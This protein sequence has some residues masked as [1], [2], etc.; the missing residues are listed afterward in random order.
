MQIQE[1][2]EVRDLIQR[3]LAEDVADGDATTLALVPGDARVKAEIVARHDCV[4]AGGPVAA[5]VFRA[6]DEQVVYE[7]GVA[8]GETVAQ[9]ARVATIDGPARGILTAERT[10][11][12]LTA[13]DRDRDPD[14]AVC[15]SRQSLRNHDSGYAQD[16][17][18]VSGIGKVCC[19]LWGWSQPSHGAL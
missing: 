16:D 11:E 7:A 9:G 10:A 18:R 12:F 2:P 8:D 4:M 3:A 5:A 14:G 19:S 6:V 13:I 17:A 15:R 1:T